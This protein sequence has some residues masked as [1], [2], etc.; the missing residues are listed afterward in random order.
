MKTTLSTS[1]ASGTHHQEDGL[2]KAKC[3]YQLKLSL[4]HGEFRD[5]CEKALG[6]NKDNISTC[7]KWKDVGVW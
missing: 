1:S 5:V 2:A 4:N 6:W 3:A 7:L